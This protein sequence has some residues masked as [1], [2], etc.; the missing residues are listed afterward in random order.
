[1]FMDILMIKPEGKK[2]ILKIKQ[3]ND[4]GD[5]EYCES[6]AGCT[7]NVCLIANGIIYVANAGDSRTL[8]SCKGKP[9]E[10]SKDH[11]PDDE[12]E[13]NRITK[14]GGFF[15]KYRWVYFVQ[16]ISLMVELMVTLISRDVL[17]ISSIKRMK[18]SL[19]NSSLSQHIQTS[20]NANLPR[21]T[22]S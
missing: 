19:K 22:S 17:E 16:A 15:F 8:L 14:A 3:D 7:A 2:E 9:V 12:I 13:F 1:M 10:M 20:K 6:L 21:T 5:G 18:N 4:S 11:K